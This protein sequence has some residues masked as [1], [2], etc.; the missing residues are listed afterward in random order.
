VAE[1]LLLAIEKSQFFW[2]L[3]FL[4]RTGHSGAEISHCTLTP[5]RPQSPLRG[6]NGGDQDRLALVLSYLLFTDA[7]LRKASGNDRSLMHIVNNGCDRRL[8]PEDKRRPR[9]E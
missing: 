3:L 7:A 4:T 6:G 9:R 5:T 1:C 8:Y 2:A